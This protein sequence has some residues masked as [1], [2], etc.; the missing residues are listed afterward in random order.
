MVISKEQEAR[1]R[2]ADRYRE[3]RVDIVQAIERRVIGG[4]WGAN[5]YTTIAQADQLAE[6]L[7][8]S[9]GDLLLD[10]GAGRGWPGLYLAATTGCSVVLTDLPLEGL[11]VADARI[12]TEHLEARAWCANASARDVPFPA[13]TFDAVVHTDVLC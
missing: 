10:V 11:T 13:D 4:D 7:H 2:F 1:D 9:P 8:L 3:E 12:R 6:Y 5:G